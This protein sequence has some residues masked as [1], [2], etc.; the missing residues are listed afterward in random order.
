M[1]KVQCRKGSGVV[2]CSPVWCFC[3]TMG[4]TEIC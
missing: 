2:R 3:Q 4:T 1:I